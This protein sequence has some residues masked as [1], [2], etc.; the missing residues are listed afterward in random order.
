M[1]EARAQVYATHRRWDPWYHFFAFSVVSISFFIALWMFIK[2]LAGGFSAWAAWNVVAWVAAIALTLRIRSYPLKLQDRIIRLEERLR[3]GTLL[4]EPLR[5]RI[6]ELDVPQLVGL[7]FASD[8][9]VP[10][11]V[12]AALDEGLSGEEIKKR[13]QTWRPDTLRV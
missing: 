2:S 11:L 7:R 10:G 6:G 4:D 1:P 9:E 8:A 13:I 3:L 12:K 5:A